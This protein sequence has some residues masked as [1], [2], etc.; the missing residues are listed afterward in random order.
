MQTDYQLIKDYKENGNDIAFE[1]LFKRHKTLL[2]IYAQK[3][4]TTFR[5]YDRSKDFNHH[6][7]ELSLAFCEAIKTVKVYRMKEDTL[8]KKRLYYYMRGYNQK[9][10]K[11]FNAKGRR[12]VTTK[13]NENLENSCEIVEPK[14]MT[15]RVENKIVL[16]NVISGAKKELNEVELKVFNSIL[17]NRT[18]KEIAK[19]LNCTKQ[20]VYM[21]KGRIAKKLEKYR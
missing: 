18:P 9:L 14:N 21:V 3:M 2:N 5:K 20:Y 17:N 13:E 16:E 1:I 11:Y 7:S 15:I 4:Y 6:F 19:S 8:F 10:Y 12:V